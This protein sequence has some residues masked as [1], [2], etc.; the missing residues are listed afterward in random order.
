MII[1]IAALKFQLK[2]VKIILISQFSM[3]VNKI[4]LIHNIVKKYLNGLC[5]FIQLDCSLTSSD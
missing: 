3:Y 2:Y 5:R 4:L 1:Y